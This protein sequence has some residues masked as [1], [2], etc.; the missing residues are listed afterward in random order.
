MS[1][2]GVS[3]VGSVVSSIVKVAE[4]MLVFP[5]ASVAVNVTVANPVAP[6]SSLNVVKSLLKVTPLH[7]SDA[8][9][10]PLEANHAASC[11]AFPPPSHSTVMS[12][13]GVSIVGSVVSS[14]V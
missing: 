7:A 12:D 8:A 1:D 3:I 2:A 4:I 13:A 14:I 10:P 11:A 5:H 6:Q 9:A